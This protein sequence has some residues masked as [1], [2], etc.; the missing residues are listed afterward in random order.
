MRCQ[1]DFSIEDW[2]ALF[3]AVRDRLTYAIDQFGAVSSATPLQESGDLMKTVVLESV[4]ALDQ[5]HK[6]VKH[7]CTCAELV[8]Q[9]GKIR[10]NASRVE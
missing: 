3:H 2:D 7:E 8:W 5:L 9:S 4:E 6:V 10:L 1:K